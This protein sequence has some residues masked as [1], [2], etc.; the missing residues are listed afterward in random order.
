MTAMLEDRAL[1]END[2]VI[3]VTGQPQSPFTI[4]ETYEYL[5]EEW[6]TTAEVLNSREAF[7]IFLKGW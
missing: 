6:E 1:S 4:K 3:M 5:D 2:L 7:N